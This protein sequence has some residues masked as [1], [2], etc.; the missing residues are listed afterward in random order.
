MSHVVVL[1][2]GD[3]GRSPRMQYHA[4]SF[5]GM[6]SVQRVSLVGY[7]GEQ[8]IQGVRNFSKIY[9]IR[10]KLFSFDWLRRISVLH[11]VFR[12]LGLLLCTIKVLLSLPYYDKIIIQNPPALPALIAAIFVDLVPW[13]SSEIIIDWHN[14]GFAMFEENLGKKHIVV[15]LSK[16]MEWTLSRF[17][18]GHICVSQAM[19][20]WLKDNFGANCTVLYDRP[21]SSFQKKGTPLAQR[22]SLFTKLKLTHRHIFPDAQAALDQHP[23]CQAGHKHSLQTMLDSAGRVV[24]LPKALSVPVLLSST[25]WTPDEDFQLLLSAL[26]LLETRL[27]QAASGTGEGDDEG[28]PVL[29]SRLLVVITGKG[30]MKEEFLAAAEEKVQTGQLGRRVAVRTLWLEAEDY[31]PLVG[32][33]ELGICLHTSTSGLDLPMKVLDMFGAGKS[34]FRSKSKI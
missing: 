8:S 2:L 19:G 24:P 29:P 26:C 5:A 22:H 34:K 27:E 12:G 21:A 10:L 15:K 23:E 31:P 1:V 28:R 3:T 25:S 4:V 16:F 18:N 17:A 13:R 14:L 33:A 6:K 7:E 30:P 32:C 20:A 11:A 9:D